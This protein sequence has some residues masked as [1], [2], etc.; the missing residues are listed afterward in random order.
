MKGAGPF[1]RAMILAA[2]RGEREEFA[3]GDPPGGAGVEFVTVVTDAPL[4]VYGKLGRDSQFYIAGVEIGGEWPDAPRHD[5]GPLW[6][7]ADGHSRVLVL[8]NP[9]PVASAMV[10]FMI[11]R[12]RAFGPAGLNDDFAAHQDCMARIEASRFAKAVLQ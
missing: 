5:G 11:R 8:R 12:I 1:S 10:R 3:V 4:Q 7:W 9:E 2:T 6:A